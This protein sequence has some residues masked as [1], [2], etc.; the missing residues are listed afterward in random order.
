MQEYS[1][2]L[3]CIFVLVNLNKML[4]FIYLLYTIRSFIIHLDFSSIIITEY[5]INNIIIPQ[6]VIK[7]ISWYFV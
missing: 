1:Y 3:E 6:F 4:T 2:I 5:I 7:L